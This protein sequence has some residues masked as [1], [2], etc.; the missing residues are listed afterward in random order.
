MKKY[1]ILLCSFFFFLFIIASQFV[2]AQKNVTLNGVIKD[3]S[4]GETLIGASIQLE[5]LNKIGTVTNAY[6]FYSISLNPGAY[7]LIYSY[8]G[9][10]TQTKDI[11]IEKDLEINISLISTNE[12]TEVVVSAEKKNNNIVNPLMGV[13]KLNVKEINS[14]P[15]LFGERD[16]L[17][18]LQLL[19]GISSAGEGNS[20]FYVRGGSVD[21]NL[22]LLDEAPVYNASHLLGF[23]STFNSDAIKDVTVYKGGMPAEYGGRL[24]SVLDIK[25]NDGNKKEYTAEGGIGLIASRLKLEGPFKKDKSSFMISGRRTYA[26]TFLAFAK[27]TSIRDNTLYFYD[28][29]AKA[30]YQI[31]KKN[32]LYLSGYFG[33]DKLGLS[34]TFGFEWGNATGT[35]RWNHLISNKLFSNTSLIYSKYDYKIENLLADNNFQV[36][37]SIK[38]Y[39]FKQD[40]QLAADNNHDVKFGV[41][42][43]YHTIEP[44]KLT[45]DGNSSV[46]QITIQ[47]RKGAE[48]A[49]Y[50]SDEWRVNE[51]LNI[52]YG[53]RFSNF[54]LFGAG[55]F[56]NYD[57]EGNIT[58]TETYKAGEIV[59][60]YFNLEPRFSA[61][62]QLTSSKAIKGSFTR[63]TQNL[64]LMSNST[65]TS[66]TDLYI[67]NSNNT[68]PEIAD[69]FSLGYFNNFKNDTYEFSA[70]VYYK[71]MQNQIDY[72]SGTDLRGNRNVEADLVY[73]QGRAYGIELFLKKR[74]GDFNG[75]VG[76]TLSKT[77]RQFD[78][79]N[80]GNWFNALQDRTHDVSVVGIYKASKRWTFSSTFVYNTGNAVTYPNGKYQL[81][82]ST[83]FYYSERNAYRAPDY[84]RLDLAANLE[85]KI[86]PNKKYQSSWSFSVY[87]AYARKNAFAIDFREDPDNVNKTQVVRTNLFGLI[88]SVTWNFKF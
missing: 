20:G 40:F 41:N 44:G 80:Q 54:T 31:D 3:N 48:V 35:L 27:D 64:H 79:I 17:K 34:N 50:F 24:S 60:N 29:N 18:T 88:P 84:H 1:K 28:F 71:K 83:V 39:N 38:D 55:T 86:V 56:N 53:T 22:I 58:G 45:A 66:P 30:N 26:D 14:I 16:I 76:Y 15:V 13:Q 21:Q 78:L 75:W 11:T 72:R 52:V 73:G 25:M 42:L 2:Q 32:V 63:N 6:G 47:N 87:N 23:F 49:A 46:N 51:N 7:R 82:G 65:A 85:P 61:S 33:R 70:E 62:Y 37:S 59:T 12:L 43:I 74:F 67:M 19:P 57:V 5:S 81:N 69:Q 77:E 9:Y 36:N 68:K 10:Q 4:T 8:V